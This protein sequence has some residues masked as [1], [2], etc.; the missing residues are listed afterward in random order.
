MSWKLHMS[1][2]SKGKALDP[3]KFVFRGLQ[4]QTL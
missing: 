1:K 4:T 2:V 3:D